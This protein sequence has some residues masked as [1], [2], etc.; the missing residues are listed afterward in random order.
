MT[1]HQ[2]FSFMPIYQERVWGGRALEETL[3]RVLPSHGPFGESWEMVDRP[4]AQSV[5]ADGA[6]KSV[7]LSELWLRHREPVF[8]R[9]AP[10]GGRFPLLAKI[11]DA[12]ETLSVQVH[13]PETV[14]S[15]L[16]GEPK[17]EMWYVM[18]AQ[19]HACIYAGFRPGVMRRQFE[20]ALDS[21]RVEALLHR[22]PVK[23]GDAIFIPSGRCHAIG[24][25]CLI[26]EIQQNSDT[27]YRVFDWNRVGVDGRPRQL[28][29]RESLE[30]ID[31]TDYEPGLIS[32][33]GARLVESQW[34]AVDCFEIPAGR[35]IVLEDAGFV[36]VL[37]G[38]V[39]FGELVFA[40]GS[41]FWVP[42]ESA[43]DLEGVGGASRVLFTTFG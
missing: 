4:E 40:R 19:P 20:E 30:S 41:S 1:F 28:H 42:A 14:A 13:P 32:P 21:G 10:D 31:F 15:R 6:C 35:G 26:A 18:A 2:P 11:L 38:Q 12:R 16:R 9:R 25:G 17:T 8:G 22:I 24:G 7:S 33:A 23:Q 34:F 37:E 27:T 43:R 5:V 36:M 39:R 29:V 3:G